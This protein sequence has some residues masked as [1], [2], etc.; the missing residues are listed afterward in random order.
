MKK[1]ISIS[2]VLL[3]VLTSVF[4]FSVSAA[5]ADTI[6]HNLLPA[7][8]DAN[9]K[10]TATD[11][12]IT[13]NDDGSVTFTITGNVPVVNVVFA[14]GTTVYSGEPFNVKEGKGYVVFDY[15]SS[16]GANL[17]GTGGTVAH[18][19]RK[20]KAAS[21]GLADLFLTSMESADYAAYSK[22]SG[23]GYGIWSLAEYIVKGKGDAGTFDDGMHRI[24]N[25]TYALAGPVGSSVTVYRFYVGTADAV[26]GIGTVRPEA[27]EVPVVPGALEEKFDI[28]EN[29]KDLW[30]KTPVNSSNI[31]IETADGVTVVGG[32]AAGDYPWADA[33]LP[34]PVL[35]GQGAYLVYDLTF[36]VGSTSLRA[37][38]IAFHQLFKGASIQAGSNDLLPGTY[39]GAVSYDE[40]AELLG[41]NEE[42]LVEINKL[43]V[44]SVAGA[45]ITFNAFAFDPSYVPEETPDV[46]E[47]ETSTPA[48]DSSEPAD[49]SSEPADESSAPATSEDDSSEPTSDEKT[50]VPATGVIIGIVVGV[51]A[52]VAVVVIIIVVAKKKK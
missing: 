49:D 48:D 16:D 26:E 36:D 30:V 37:N 13:Y 12:E 40:L 1:L 6:I 47:P 24:D 5:E 10:V 7:A 11:C 9:G 3:L 50:N 33:T 4:A 42:G 2:V 14:E 25:I 17:N 46:S 27:P 34:V 20:D 39:K 51:V 38:E 15:G 8:N 45:E 22:V 52:V 32:S 29:C 31:T 19:T 43:T 35:L 21:G 23:E 44:F 41:T 28:F 18:Y